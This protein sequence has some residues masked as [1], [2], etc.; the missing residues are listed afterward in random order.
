MRGRARSDASPDRADARD[1]RIVARGNRGRR[2]RVVYQALALFLVACSA[3]YVWTTLGSAPRPLPEATR[4]RAQAVKA[5]ADGRRG[6]S[7]T[8]DGAPNDTRSEMRIPPARPVK[9]RRADPPRA[10]PA[11]AGEEESE[12]DGDTTPDLSDFWPPGAA[13]TAGE[14]IEQLHEAGIYSGIGAFSPP[15]TSPPLVGLA[16]PDD[17]E[18]PEGYVRHFQA[19]DDG[20]RI[21]PI[22]MFSPDYEFFDADGQPIEIPEN[23]VVPPELAPSGLPIRYIEI[24]SSEREPGD[25]SR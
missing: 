21:E 2:A 25:A 13:P 3:A 16:V 20:K 10:L 9:A 6:A 14:V 15:G 5:V 23:R 4:A 22:L 12:P 7:K 18:L 24:P 17:F 19:T 1:V 11:R 8:D